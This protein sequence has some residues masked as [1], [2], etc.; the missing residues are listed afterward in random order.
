[1]AVIR[2]F[3]DTGGLRCV[4]LIEDRGTFTFRECRRDPEDRGRWSLV[5]DFSGRSF[6]SAEEALRAAQAAIGWF[7]GGA[8]R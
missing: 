1:M 8:V 6:P 3:E 4:D 5:A 7:D 2:S